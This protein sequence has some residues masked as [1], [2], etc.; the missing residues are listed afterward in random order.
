MDD[1][2][3]DMA[4]NL[5]RMID[6]NLDID[7]KNY[8]ET[9]YTLRLQPIHWGVVGDGARHG[10]W[11]HFVTVEDLRQEYLDIWDKLDTFAIPF[12]E[13]PNSTWRKGM[14]FE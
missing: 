7:N 9:F 3:F 11:W 8:P 14:G 13:D 4:V 10:K 1:E 5:K 12:L 2:F 6:E